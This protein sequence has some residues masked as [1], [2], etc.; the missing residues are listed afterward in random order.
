[1]NETVVVKG[2]W[3]SVRV[4]ENADELAS[5]GIQTCHISARAFPVKLPSA[6]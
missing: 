5:D 4:A 1:M 2:F 6:A 3:G